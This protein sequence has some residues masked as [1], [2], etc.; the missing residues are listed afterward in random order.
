ML[1]EFV[2]LPGAG[3]TSLQGA[4]EHQAKLAGL[5][6]WSRRQLID[7][8]ISESSRLPRD[9]AGVLRRAST[10]L[11]KFKLLADCVA[12]EKIPL[13]VKDIFSK[14]TLRALLRVAEDVRLY[15]ADHSENSLI[16]YV[17]LAEGL[18]QHLAALEVWRTL[19]GGASMSENQIPIMKSA[20]TN[21]RVLIIHVDVPE[22]IALDRLRVRGCPDLW[23]RSCAPEIVIPQFKQHISRTL[24][25]LKSH[26][27]VSVIQVD[28]A[29]ARRDWTLEAGQVVHFIRSNFD[30]ENVERHSRCV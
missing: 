2:G 28:G 3:K 5:N 10:A 27:G 15:R 13:R 8:L 20:L 1:V 17:V 16:R 12:E 30:A 6:L 29:M 19:L 18:C 22:N 14:H 25:F 7:R 4:F 9:G 26:Q 24:D 21:C 23:P 11:Y